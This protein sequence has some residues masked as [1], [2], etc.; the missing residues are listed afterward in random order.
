MKICMKKKMLDWLET[1]WK[2]KINLF[3]GN[4]SR[5]LWSRNKI[6]NCCEKG[7]CPLKERMM[8]FSLSFSELFTFLY[9]VSPQMEINYTIFVFGMLASMS[10]H[11]QFSAPRFN[12]V[13]LVRS[14][15]KRTKYLSQD[16]QIFKVSLSVT[17][18]VPDRKSVNMC[19][20]WSLVLFFI[21][22][23]SYTS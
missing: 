8:H 4:K 1:E 18:L 23:A 5:K 6:M 22:F 3:R 21:L 14:S 20:S 16:R 10:K 15:T 11:T 2:M 17:C 19:S 9:K 7:S 13:P 12:I